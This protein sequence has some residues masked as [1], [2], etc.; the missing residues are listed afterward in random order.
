MSYISQQLDVMRESQKQVV[1]DLVL[2][3][4]FPKCIK[5]H[6][7]RECLVDKVE[8]CGLYDLEHE[9]KHFPSLP[10]AKEIFQAST[11]EIEQAYFI[12]QKKP[13][14][15]HA[16]GMNPDPTYFNSRNNM[17]NHLPSQYYYPN[18]QQN[19]TNQPTMKNPTPWIP[20]E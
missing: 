17:N 14:K 18:A 12:S 1:E 8:V 13:W 3:V 20:W 9:N 19:P 10:K 5:K 4:F 11:V 16:P 2:G 6:T 15:P 7:L